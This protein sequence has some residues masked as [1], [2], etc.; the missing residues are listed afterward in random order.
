MRSDRQD[1]V[2]SDL[3]VFPNLVLLNLMS[4]DR[5]QA[6]LNL[7]SQDRIWFCRISCH[8]MKFDVTEFD[9]TG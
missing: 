3:I 7:V 5:I 2:L 6:L 4:R 1:F 9:A 8:G